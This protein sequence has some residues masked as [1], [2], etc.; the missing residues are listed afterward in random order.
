MG[1][2]K[3]KAVVSADADQLGAVKDLVQ[4]GRYRTV[5]EFVREAMSEKLERLRRDEL[6]DQVTRYSEEED[7]DDEL[8]AWQ[9]FDA[10]AV[11]RGRRAKG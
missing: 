4:Q 2:A 11:R 6:A 10:P 9:A 5:S 7:R 3:R 8:I 1:A